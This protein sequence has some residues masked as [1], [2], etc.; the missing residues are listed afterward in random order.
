MAAMVRKEGRTFE[1]RN[2]GRR[3]RYVVEFIHGTPFLVYNAYDW[4][5]G[6]RDKKVYTNKDK[7][8]H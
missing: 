1:H 5:N 8:M 4:I 2:I 6:A 3:K 7:I